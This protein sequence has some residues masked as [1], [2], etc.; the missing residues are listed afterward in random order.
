[1]IWFRLIIEVE[2]P[3]SA[4]FLGVAWLV[5]DVGSSEKQA[6]FRNNVPLVH[7]QA[8][9]MSRNQNHKTTFVT[10]THLLMDP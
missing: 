8:S 6:N 4:N 5:S 9:V 1:M 10:Q 2:N 3:V 7:L